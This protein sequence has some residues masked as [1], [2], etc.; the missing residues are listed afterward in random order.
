MII[1][2]LV[3]KCFPHGLLILIC[4]CIKN[5]ILRISLLPIGYLLWLLNSKMWVVIRSKIN[6]VKQNKTLLIG[7]G[8]V[9][10]HS[11]F[12]LDLFW[13]SA[14]IIRLLVYINVQVVTLFHK[15]IIY[16]FIRKLSC[17]GYTKVIRLLCL[18]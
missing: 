7:D 3:T 17:Y 15:S 12:D 4:K 14:W 13:P 9:H 16:Y 10:I 1:L 6:F 8:H 11:C 2:S 18:F 5:D